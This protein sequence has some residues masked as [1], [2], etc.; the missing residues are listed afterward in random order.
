MVCAICEEAGRRPGTVQA[1]IQTG[2][3]SVASASRTQLR[4]I[5]SL[6]LPGCSAFFVTHLS[7]L[8]THSVSNTTHKPNQHPRS[9]PNTLPNQLNSPRYPSRRHVTITKHCPTASAHLDHH[10]GEGRCEAEL[11]R[12]PAGA[13]KRHHRR[14]QEAVSDSRYI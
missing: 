12:G 3:F 11:L 8:T 10:H 5:N 2:I 7:D 9:K 14:D 1:H 13:P 4:T 6:L